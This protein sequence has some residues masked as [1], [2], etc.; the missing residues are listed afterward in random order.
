MSIKL[1]PETGF[2]RLSS[3]IGAPN[4]VPPIPA[5]LPISRSCWYEGIKSGRFPKPL[6]I[7]GQRI[8]LYRVEDIRRLLESGSAQLDSCKED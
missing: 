3:I 6:K 7:Y 8:A 4:A 1:L 2:I 5:L